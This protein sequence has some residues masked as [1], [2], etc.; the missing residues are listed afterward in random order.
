MK[1]GKKLSKFRHPRVGSNTL[2]GANSCI[3]GNI[4]IGSNVKI[5]AGSVVLKSVPDNV[6]AV[7][8]PAKIVN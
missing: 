6:S 8:I 4:D 3:I 2:I 1:K 7:G 5:G